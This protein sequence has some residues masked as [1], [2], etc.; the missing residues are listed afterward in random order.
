MRTLAATQCQKLQHERYSLY[1]ESNRCFFVSTLGKHKGEWQEA[2]SKARHSSATLAVISD[3]ELNNFISSLV[4][5]SGTPGFQY[6][7]GIQKKA[8]AFFD[9]NNNP[10]S[11]SNNLVAEKP[12]ADGCVSLS[13]EGVWHLDECSVEHFSVLEQEGFVAQSTSLP[14]TVR[15]NVDECETLTAEVLSESIFTIPV[16]LEATPT[17]EI[18][19]TIQTKNIDCRY[20]TFG[21][22]EWP[23]VSIRPLSQRESSTRYDTANRVVF[24][25]FESCQMWRQEQ[26]DETQFV[27]EVHCPA[28]LDVY[29]WLRHENIIK[30]SKEIIVCVENVAQREMD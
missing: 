26:I 25:K 20:E 13:R 7:I 24:G 23:L 10:V 17:S 12:A 22:S 29:I 8:N 9:V 1:D 2:V 15:N 19:L 18:T 30:S 27:C 4:A 3:Q 11:F 28:T 6:W 21:C 5:E 14:Y 16:Y